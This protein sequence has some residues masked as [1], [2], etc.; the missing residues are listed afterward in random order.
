MHQ[1]ACGPYD[2]IPKSPSHSWMW[3]SLASLLAS[4]ALSKHQTSIAGFP[5]TTEG[6]LYCKVTDL[7]NIFMNLVINF[8]ENWYSRMVQ[9][10]DVNGLLIAPSHLKL[11][12]GWCF[13]SRPYHLLRCLLANKSP[14]GTRLL[15]FAGALIRFLAIEFAEPRQ[16]KWLFATGGGKVISIVETAFEALRTC[17]RGRLSA[18]EA[19]KL[20]EWAVS[21]DLQDIASGLIACGA[22]TYNIF[23]KTHA[24]EEA[25]PATIALLLRN[26]ADAQEALRHAAHHL[27]TDNH[28][29]HLENKYY[30]FYLPL[31]YG[32][33]PD[34]LME[35]DDCYGPGLSD[36]LS[37]A[38]LGALRSSKLGRLFLPYVKDRLRKEMVQVFLD[39]HE[40]R[41]VCGLSPTHREF[42]LIIATVTG[43]TQMVDKLLNGGTDPNCSKL[44]KINNSRSLT[45]RLVKELSIRAQRY[46]IECLLNSVLRSGNYD[47]ARILL[48][49][50]SDLRK[51][52]LKEKDRMEIKDSYQMFRDL[53]QELFQPDRLSYA[54]TFLLWPA[55]IDYDADMI[56][57][58]A[59]AGVQMDMELQ[60]SGQTLH[61]LGLAVCSSTFEILKLLWERGARFRDHGPT[62]G[63]YEL[64]MLFQEHLLL[65]ETTPDEL[66]MKFDFLVMKGACVS[67]AVDLETSN[68]SRG[69]IILTPLESLL[70]GFPTDNYETW[71]DTMTSLINAGAEINHLDRSRRTP[72]QLA[73]HRGLF[74]IMKYLIDL[75]AD[76]NVH[77]SDYCSPF[78]VACSA[79]ESS[80]IADNS[81]EKSV[82]REQIIDIFLA[83]GVDVGSSL[84]SGTIPY[85]ALGV[86]C[87]AQCL[88]GVRLLLDRGASIEVKS[89]RMWPGNYWNS[90]TGGVEVHDYRERTPLQLACGSAKE[91]D[92]ELIS[93][94][95]THDANPNAGQGDT[96]TALQEA[97][98]RENLP[99][100]RL[101]IESG[102]EA[103]DSALGVAPAL[104]YAVFN[105]HFSLSL[106][107]IEHGADATFKKVCCAQENRL[108]WNG[109][110]LRGPYTALEIAAKRG[111]Y[112]V[113]RLL[114]NAIIESG[115][116]EDNF[117]QAIDLAIE[118]QHIQVVEL[119]ESH[120]QLAYI[121]DN[122]VP[123]MDL[124][125]T[126]Q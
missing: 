94:L 33:N 35:Q 46:E 41:A 126:G 102:A 4:D 26:G 107:L 24:I 57:K 54:Q 100:A 81:L 118:Q 16:R 83:N 53:T 28:S 61:T 3:E 72:L 36:D 11:I 2:S 87:T 80:T 59:D 32:A 116:V 101:L 111:H 20:L 123:L 42:A 56:I 98:D 113:V 124:D 29:D 99:L 88:A 106:L 105:G 7:L 91:L 125:L 8:F 90:W 77:D 21:F 51:D 82:S 48:N 73:A 43:A 97:A 96:R 23:S 58:L 19:T 64:V 40:G 44:L 92:L 50:G 93:L 89:C 31:A 12:V 1:I 17:R 49:A 67:A 119:L 70:Q 65:D 55:I 115:A 86:A 34:R 121:P 47:L 112:D 68:G 95:L 27:M 103:N 117:S 10:F 39:I 69:N 66:A 71:F 110:E 104:H 45:D 63:A 38:E 13:S 52:Y 74:H 85:T 14:L 78:A 84:V 108:R 15:T 122:D 25:G 30:T 120:R 76:L 114:I 79:P 62:E 5:K 75:G 60:T 9:V 109:D 18:F 6:L 22:K 37:I